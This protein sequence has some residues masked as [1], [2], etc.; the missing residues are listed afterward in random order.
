MDNKL[1]VIYINLI[2]TDVLNNFLQIVKKKY[3]L[4]YF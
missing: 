1:L 3:S 4:V 2:F